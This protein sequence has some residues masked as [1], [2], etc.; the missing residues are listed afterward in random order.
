VDVSRR[1]K[2]I[3]QLTN[4]VKKSK[5][6]NILRFLKT[7]SFDYDFLDESN[8]MLNDDAVDET[9]GQNSVEKHV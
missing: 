7:L 4:Q 9:D 8:K 5:K 3:H 6:Y 2:W 1:K